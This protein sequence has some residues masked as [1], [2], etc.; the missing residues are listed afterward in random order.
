M[1]W[2]GS[3]ADLG[4]ALHDALREFGLERKINEHALIDSWK[5]FVDP[6]IANNTRPVRFRNGILI[7][8]VDSAAWRHELTT[9]RQELIAMLNARLGADIVEGIVFR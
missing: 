1:K 6:A 5:D 8:E 3:Q 4:G 9:R 2:P 7:V